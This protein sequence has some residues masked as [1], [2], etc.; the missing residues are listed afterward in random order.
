MLGGLC[1]LFQVSATDCGSE[2]KTTEQSR[3]KTQTD[4][5]SS[6]EVK[7]S[8]FLLNIGCRVKKAA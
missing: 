4:S 5:K 1:K 3:K 7:P 2:I 8:C 6:S